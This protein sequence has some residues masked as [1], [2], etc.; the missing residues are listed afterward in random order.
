MCFNIAIDGPAGAGKSTI[1]KTVAEK[2]NMTYIDTGAMY[3]AFTLKALMNNIKSIQEIIEMIKNTS[4]E[5]IN[6]KVFLDGK[7]VTDKIRERQITQTVSKIAQIPE[8][9]FFLVEMQKKMAEKKGVVMD[10]RDIGTTVLPDAEYKFFLTAEI[11]E[12]ARRRFE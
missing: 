6:N 2:L 11:K 9:R 12:R 8:V 4:I 7:D 1:A 3:R 10:G 5:I